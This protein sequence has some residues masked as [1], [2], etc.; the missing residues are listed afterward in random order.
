MRFAFHQCKASMDEKVDTI[1]R[2]TIVAVKRLLA[3]DEH[4]EIVDSTGSDISRND[5]HWCACYNFILMQ[6][7]R[8]VVFSDLNS[9]R[10][11]F[12]FI[13]NLS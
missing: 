7:V 13:T 8:D 4:T 1:E 6:S 3:N 10:G 11:T 5:L 2:G 9:F 12:N